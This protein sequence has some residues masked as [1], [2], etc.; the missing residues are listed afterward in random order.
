[1]DA[2]HFNALPPENPESLFLTTDV[3]DDGHLADL[4]NLPSTFVSTSN[5]FAL[6]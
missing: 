1:M 4:Y 3:S 6:L 5:H 2:H